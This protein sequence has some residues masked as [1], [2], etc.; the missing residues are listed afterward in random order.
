MNWKLLRVGVIVAILAACLI[1]PLPAG[2]THTQAGEGGQSALDEEGQGRDRQ[3]SC[4]P[5]VSA[6][7]R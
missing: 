4:S 2:A 6:T 7:S 5:A 1:Q 3:R